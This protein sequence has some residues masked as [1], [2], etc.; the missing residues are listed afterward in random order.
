MSGNYHKN[1]KIKAHW[2]QGV[3]DQ[4]PSSPSFCNDPKTSFSKYLQ[5]TFEKYFLSVFL[6]ANEVQCYPLKNNEI[7]SVTFRSPAKKILFFLF[8]CLFN[9]VL[10]KV[11]TKSNIQIIECFHSY[12]DVSLNEF[13]QP[14]HNKVRNLQNQ[15]RCIIALELI[16]QHVFQRSFP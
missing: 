5:R 4:S 10:I 6:F 15:I 9:A 3:G 16:F 11:C 13:Q 8:V 2:K 14:Y 7:D 1:V 12:F